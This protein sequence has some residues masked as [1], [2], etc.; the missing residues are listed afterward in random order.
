MNQVL[1]LFDFIAAQLEHL[2]QGMNL[3]PAAVRVIM[4]AIRVVPTASFGLVL[5][6]FLIWL[7][8]KLAAR[9]QDRLGPNRVGP[10]GLLQTFADVF[11]LITKEDTT[12]AGADK[13]V[14]NL[15][16]PLAVMSVVMI[17]AV[18]PFAVRAVGVSLNVGVVYVV[19]VGGLGTMAIMLAGMS[20]NNKY[21]L[22]GAFRTVAQLV[23]YEAPMIITLLVPVMLAG[24]M[25]M[26]HIVEAQRQV[27]FVVMAPIPFLIF[28]I[29]SIAEVG[30]TPFDLLEAESEIVAGFHIEYSGMKFAMFFAAEFL[31][32]FTIS[33]LA[34]VLFFGGW[35]GPWAGSS[36]LLGVIYFLLKS[37][38]FYFIVVWV[39]TTLPRIRI[40]HMLNFNWKFITPLSL[41][42]VVV[43]AVAGKAIPA[44]SAPDAAWARAG[45]LL[46]ANFAL[47]LA[48]IWLLRLAAV[49]A[50]ARYAP[51]LVESGL[52]AE[53]SHGEAAAHAAEPNPGA[54]VS[55][56][57]AAG[58][59]HRP[60]PFSPVV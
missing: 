43:I 35:Q 28:F 10:Y 11:K 50:R 4:D 16:P 39:R 1:N 13:V 37:F 53:A 17:W 23:S 54:G 29:S 34:A 59:L 48:T 41:A 26:G 32:A 2:L 55:R 3:T 14:F 30:R 60:P 38:V 52:E 46:L 18:L 57:E 21:A 56:D 45:V 19:A 9:F 31:H 12:P 24:S 5:V 49:R 27:W 22:L 42:A 20:S 15:A 40:D 47:G 51:A 58:G 33:A 7:E 25:N 6:I 8:R 36:Q 44:G